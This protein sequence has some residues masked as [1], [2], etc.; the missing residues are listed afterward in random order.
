VTATARRVRYAVVGLGHI[1]QAAVLPAFSGAAANS[2]LT[3]VVS[4]DPAKR[5]AIAAQYGVAASFSYDDYDTCLQS[6]DAVYLTLPNRLHAEY[7]IR[8]AA[9]NVHVLCE[10]PLAV[11]IDECRRMIAAARDHRVKLMVAYRLHFEELTHAVQQL[12]HAGRIGDPRFF[13]SSFAFSMSEGN[14]RTEP[15]SSGGGTLYDIGVYCI[16]A[17][18]H[19]FKSEPTEVLALESHG[20]AA[21]LARIDES[22]AAILR[23]DGGR[24]ASFITS[25]NTA[26]VGW[27]EIVGTRGRIR[28]DPAFTY[29]EALAYEL[30]VDGQTEQHRADHRDQFADQLRHF[31][32]CV[33]QGREPESPGEE[34]LR[35]V[36]VIAAL[37]ESAKSGSTIRLQPI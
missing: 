25:F 13:T 28:V 22:T 20:G 32:D 19:L 3:A 36:A 35:D 29:R 4:S 37:L 16:N 18:R 34:G 11:T 5:Q 9:A 21:H 24:L 10:K 7:G 23:F 33:L 15:L 31:S 2:E 26:G 12:V 1:A 14:S 30:T 27:Y 8:A 6:V 17:A